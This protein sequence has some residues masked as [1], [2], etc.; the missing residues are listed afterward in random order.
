MTSP[1]MKTDLAAQSPAD[2]VNTA[3]RSTGEREL[4][5]AGQAATVVAAFLGLTAGYS[6][7][8]FY[9]SG[10]FLIPVSADLEVSRGE[11]S[12]G[13]LVCAV[14]AA[15]F[16]PAFGK[17]LDRFGP[18]VVALLSLVG[19]AAGFLAMSL[20]GQNLPSY[21]LCSF[22][23]AMLGAGSTALSFSRLVLLAFSR[24]KGLV[25]GFVMT[26]TGVGALCLPPFL[27][28]VIEAAGWREA[29]LDLALFSGFAAL[30][31]GFLMMRFR[32]HFTPEYN[33][34]RNT[35]DSRDPAPVWRDPAFIK[36]GVM[37][38]LLAVASVSVVVH[39]V[40]IQIG[41][42]L[43]AG[44]AAKIAAAIGLSSIAGRIAAGFA[45]DHVQ[46][47]TLTFI[48]IGIAIVGTATLAVPGEVG[49][50]TSAV[51]I[52]LV[53]GAESDVLSF[54]ALRYF[55]AAQYGR[56]Y[57]YTFSLYLLGGAAG[58]TIAAFGYDLTGSYDLTLVGVGALLLLA[59]YSVSLLPAQSN[60]SITIA[61][62]VGRS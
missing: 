28:P 49:G 41:H 10:L 57:G 48:A 20:F 35:A 31:I 24:R 18:L 52:G 29:Y 61:T 11:A 25:L 36:I 14:G 53:M 51:L 39:F 37:I 46:V 9:T 1:R 62:P 40:P 16:T 26:G 33:A 47:R 42:G 6:S 27:M 23:I 59:F 8:Y 38:F 60:R 45:L 2:V 4:S 7:T 34:S 55:P 50:I 56:A 5:L 43:T 58:P 32:Q 30:I 19:L 3:P 54:L 21:L 17:A 15:L 22:L 44:D 13:P 12:L